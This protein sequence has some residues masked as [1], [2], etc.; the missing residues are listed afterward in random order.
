V[1]FC[2]QNK[3]RAKL[4]AAALSEDFVAWVEDFVAWAK[5]KLAGLGVRAALF[6]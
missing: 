2:A 1:L 4:R 3:K 6:S 5:G